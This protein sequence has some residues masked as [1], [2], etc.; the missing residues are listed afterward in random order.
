M[1]SEYHIM[2]NLE[3]FASVSVIT[4]EGPISY[5]RLPKQPTLFSYILF[6]YL[7]RK[8]IHLAAKAENINVS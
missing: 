8:Q 7:K 2:L 6:L 1:K 5:L 3:L 4:C